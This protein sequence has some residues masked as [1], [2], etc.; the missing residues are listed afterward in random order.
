MT[1][2]VQLFK[3]LLLTVEGIK[4]KLDNEIR[5]YL[6]YVYNIGHK[7]ERCNMLD[8][9]STFSFELILEFII[10]AVLVYGFGLIFYDQHLLCKH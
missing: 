6:T 8:T 10:N 9:C 7:N 2:A 3:E 4:D 5:S 1:P